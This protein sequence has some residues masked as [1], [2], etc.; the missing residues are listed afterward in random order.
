MEAKNQTMQP[1]LQPT[2]LSMDT[3]IKQAVNIAEHC[4]CKWHAKAKT[5]SLP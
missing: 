2:V 1:W 4:F 5:C 3:S